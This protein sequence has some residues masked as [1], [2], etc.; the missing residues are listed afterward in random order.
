MS[1]ANFGRYQVLPVG[2]LYQVVDRQTKAPVMFAD[3]NPAAFAIAKDAF[4][5][6]IYRIKWGIQ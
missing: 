3:G 5:W 6:V 4:S 2:G 1:I